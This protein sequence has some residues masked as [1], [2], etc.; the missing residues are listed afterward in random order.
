MYFLDIVAHIPSHKRLLLKDKLFDTF[1]Q[2]VI[3]PFSIIFFGMALFFACFNYVNARADIRNYVGLIAN[4]KN[5]DVTK[6]LDKFFVSASTVLE[7]NQDSYN[8]DSFDVDNFSTLQK[9]FVSQLK[10]VPY[11]TFISFGDAN[12]EYVGASRQLKDNS[13]RLF[14][15]SK[16]SGMTMDM[17]DVN[18]NN[19]ASK[20]IQKGELYDARSRPWFNF[21]AKN[22]KT[23]WYPVYEYVPYEG[24]GM[25][26]CAPVYS[27]KTKALKGVFTVDLA[28]KQIVTYL[29]TI[30]IGKNGVIYIAETNGDLIATSLNSDVYKHD[31][32]KFTRLNLK[33]FPDKRIN[34]LAAA[35]LTT[36]GVF[37]VD[38]NTY[39]FNTT[40]YKDGFGL[41]FTVGV[42]VAEDDFAY[43][44]IKKININLFI[45][46]IVSLLVTLLIYLL[47]KKIQRQNKQLLE[48]SLTDELTGL[49]NRRHFN[50]ELS[51]GSAIAIRNKKVMVLFMI[52]ID[53]FK[54][55]NDTYGHDAGDKCLFIVA[56]AMK[57]SAKRGSDIVARYG[58]EEFVTLIIAEDAEYVCT[59]AETMRKNVEELN[60]KHEKSE[61]N[62]VTIS[63][64][65]ASVDFATGH[66]KP[67]ELLQRADKALYAA[68]DKGR[69]TVVCEA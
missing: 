2:S 20:K 41:D 24:L 11:L 22:G 16:S 23:S 10:Y 15:A 61:F 37:E 26:V 36:N 1:R 52:D 4:E 46:I 44:F 21:A 48:M 25:G 50:E 5:R 35:N 18:E 38:G 45:T 51:I 14:V 47:S 12:G 62:K 28:L 6:H 19:T 58:G 3:T 33:T 17:F 30:N 13:I 54:Q 56:Q 67:E 43:E 64:G 31:D 8:V 49:M 55:Y 39:I 34:H 9:R 57:N 68:K 66:C 63:I 42:I 69:N 65:V 27:P 29:K 7:I 60:I 59:V 40:N 53:Y 32:K